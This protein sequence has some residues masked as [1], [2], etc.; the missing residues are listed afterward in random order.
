MEKQKRWHLVLILSVI[1]L[2]VYN[3]LPSVFFYTKPLNQPIG[4]KQAL[5]VATDIG[6][7]VNALEPQ[8]KE[9]V[10]SFAKLLGV[11]ATS[12]AIDEN[13]PDLIH[14][15]LRDP[16]EAAKMRT[17]L[18]KAGALI[19]FAPAQL[20]L[21]DDLETSHSKTVTIQRKIPV[22]FDRAE[23]DKTFTFVD[24]TDE[25]GAITPAY[26]EILG[27]RLLELGLATGG[28]SE[29]ARLVQAALD[30]PNDPRSSDYLL[31]IAQRI[32]ELKETLQGSEAIMRRTFATFTQGTQE[33][34]IRTIDTLIGSMSRQKDQLRLKRMAL[35]EQKERLS[36]NNQYL[37]TEQ[38]EQLDLLQSQE[39]RLQDALTIVNQNKAAF[40]GSSAPFTYDGLK[41]AIAKGDLSLDVSR[42]NPIIAKI[43]LDLHN[44]TMQLILHDDVSA[45][46]RAF[47]GSK[48]LQARQFDQLIFDE[49]A[50]LTR[51]SGEEIRPYK[52]NFAIA[53]SN[54]EG[55][56]SLL[57]VNLGAIAEK[58]T[59]Q[60]RHLLETSWHPRHTDLQKERFPIM[61]WA[62][63]ESLPRVEKGPAL[64]IYNPSSSNEAPEQ[65]F[66]VGSIYVVAK[67]VGQILAKYQEDTSS[68]M[69][70]SFMQDFNTLKELLSKNGYIAYPGA[71]Y[72]LSAQFARDY[73]F[74]AEDFYKNILMA[75]RED[76]QVQGT[77][78][79]ASLEFSDVKQRI[80]T[81]NRIETAIHED[82]LKWRD[83][84]QTAQINPR[85]GAHLEVPKP[86]KNPLLSN[87]ALSFKK[88]F[89]GDDRKILHWGLDLS[90]GKTVQIELRDTSGQLVTNEADINQG[91]N[92]LYNRVNKM[93]VSEVSIR[94]E[95]SH[96][97]LDFPG[98]QGL[99]AS[100]LIKAS[101][102]QFH[103]VNE[104]FS[105]RASDYAAATNRFLEEI[106]NEAVVTGK[107]DAMSIGRIA[108]N[109][110]YGEGLEGSPTPR[111]ESAKLLY[112]NGLR[113][114]N[115]DDHSVSSTFN[116]TLSKIAILRG[117]SFA[118]W[119]GNT[120]PLVIVFKNI[121]LEGSNLENVRAGYDPS[122]GNYLSFEVLS[123]QTTPEGVKLAPRATLYNW[124]SIFAK[125]K[126]AGTPLA[127]PT[128][129]EGWRMA[130][131]LNGQI[132]SSP[133]LNEALRS[134]A[135]ISGSFT[136]REI[137]RLEADLK[138]GSLTYTPTILSE[139]NVSPELGHKER[140]QGLVSAG[141]ALMLVILLMVSY[142][143][144]AGI[145]ASVAVLF[146]LL[147]MW[148]TLQNVQA[149][150]TLAGIAGAILV[151]GMAVDANVLVF[152]RIREELESGN[153]LSKAIGAGYKKAFT[154]I[155]DSNL[156]TIIA[157]L[158]LLHFDS[159]PIKGFA[160]TLIIGIVSSM[161][162]ALFLTR[163]FFTSW[164]KGQKEKSLTMSSWIKSTKFNFIKASKVCIT[165]SIAIALVGSYLLFK[166]RKTLF[167]MDFTG[168][169][170]MSFD[171]ESTSTENPRQ[172]V[173]A[174]LIAAGAP[175]QDIEVRQMN[176]PTSLRLFLGTN[177]DLK[178]K[179]FYGMPIETNVIDPLYSYQKNPR[180]DWVVESLNTQ[181]IEL[182]KAS[183]NELE[184]TF[185]SISGQMSDSMRQNAIWG[186]TIALICILI[187]IT[188]R[189]E[190][191]YAISATVCLAHDVII[192][193]GMIALLNTIGVPL[194]IDLK[195]IA[196][197]MTIVGYSLN[198]TII[199][200]DR[201]RENLRLKKKSSFVDII[202]SS[203]NRTLSRTLMTSAT[204]L[205]VLVALVIF[206][207]SS[208]FGFALV[209]TLGVIFGTLSSLFIASPIL[210]YFQRLEE[211]KEKTLKLSQK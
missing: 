107:K 187:Y 129:G 38:K 206:G 124:T 97:T 161:F 154:A 156:T 45:N 55:S 81:Q 66:R 190:F 157:A 41:A 211:E 168:G 18:P 48:S 51:Q 67:G 169:Y 27:D 12:V 112:E 26:R 155:A 39:G 138:A 167:G 178:D 204:T 102:M 5:S 34:P 32:T 83:E 132:I 170:A 79:F 93:G 175:A 177:M 174:A 137:N 15:T 180:I 130:V 90:G 43:A 24:K 136:Q 140:T 84:F 126:I 68:A 139:K 78:R 176:T 35:E 64:V 147:I 120:H 145:V 123:S 70:R 192:T 63:Y 77:K 73:I 46:L 74:E 10:T 208:I 121:A 201:I 111:S 131:I 14:V 153:R 186:L 182:T 198:D 179:P 82:L 181:G 146:N 142:Y 13:N 158:I 88:Y 62:T 16:N 162:T 7:R 59:A 105:S 152:E 89:R 199:I 195:T 37:A 86:T 184:L 134:S 148:A 31:M 25:N 44:D 160:V 23:I 164:V 22:H 3:I 99:S 72:P 117:E 19:P 163:Y 53:L 100:D 202:N 61:D 210:L 11:K 94:R 141:I 185:S 8:S 159:G 149:T 101:S 20:S 1:A 85:L 135:Q 80:L 52:E 166:E 114:S 194:P 109:H 36:A 17:H 28:V 171:V 172:D 54:L 69:A 113:L 60:L 21:A 98:A 127:T 197:L 118:E 207:G 103:I 76:F 106:W 125:S 110:L 104:K 209:M 4:E 96:I 200:F 188:F 57:K 173:A 87:L 143:R 108:F 6:K 29:N 33:T 183:L 49:I 95:G 56:Q 2:T 205:I 150:L 92:E 203:L 144:F 128:S 165:V 122:K 65:G 47:N 30:N 189:F 196:A 151:I 191:K 75:S 116:D 119:N 71:T 58:E 115:P 9:W 133:T 40:A 193:L 91:I 42:N 50:T